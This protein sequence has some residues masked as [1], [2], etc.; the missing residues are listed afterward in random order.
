MFA[1]TGLVFKF[2][3]IFPQVSVICK[4][5]IEEQFPLRDTHENGNAFLGSSIAESTRVNDTAGEEMEIMF[6]WK[7]LEI[8]FRDLC[9]ID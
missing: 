8:A 3:L 7:S 4:Y 1:Q 5:M 9:V 6:I 2:K